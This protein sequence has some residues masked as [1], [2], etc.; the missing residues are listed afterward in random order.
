MFTP[1]AMAGYASTAILTIVNLLVT[2]FILKRFL[3]KPIL[4]IL[5]K[6]K[7]DV[8]TELAQAEVK[9]TQSEEK[10][11]DANLRLDNSAH[12]AAALLTSA[13]SQ[14]EIQSETILS[15]AKRDAAGMLTR[16]DAEI[17]RMRITMLNDV[18]DEVADLSV[19]IASKVIGQV[20]DERRQRE[21]VDHFLDDQMQKSNKQAAV[22][23]SGVSGDA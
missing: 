23:Q 2:Y 12:E 16:A 1:E 18:R 6:R 10:L 22:N 20:M 4:K 13:R 8:E 19:A 3:F 9:L 7:T 21:L 15:D 14:A 5:R 17:N 11:A